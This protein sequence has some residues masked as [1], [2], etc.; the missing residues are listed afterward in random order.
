MPLAKACAPSKRIEFQLRSKISRVSLLDIAVPSILPPS[1]ENEFLERFKDLRLIL[2]Y[3]IPLKKLNLRS[4]NYTF[5]LKTYCLL[6]LRSCRYIKTPTTTS[7][8]WSIWCLL[9]IMI[10]KLKYL[11]NIS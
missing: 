2:F 9:L 7:M 4:I 11:N 5:T 10:K 1:I 8:F 3:K 6:N